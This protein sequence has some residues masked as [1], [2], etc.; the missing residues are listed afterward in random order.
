MPLF[1]GIGNAARREKKIAPHFP[2][3][4]RFLDTIRKETRELEH[5]KN[6]FW[7]KKKFSHNGRREGGG[8]FGF[9]VWPL[10]KHTKRGERLERGEKGFC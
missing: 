4:F 5:G 7:Q 8:Y 9:F 10:Y 6:N 1:L 3:N 2:F